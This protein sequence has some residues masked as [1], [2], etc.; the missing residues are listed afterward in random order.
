MFG[1]WEAKPRPEFPV[2]LTG[3][4]ASVRVRREVA[5]VR[6]VVVLAVVVVETKTL[7]RLRGEA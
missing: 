1:L 7:S 6:V 4:V 5:T 2:T 3:A